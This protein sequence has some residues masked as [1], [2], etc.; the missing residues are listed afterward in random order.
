[1]PD[2]P[3]ASPAGRP[4]EVALLRRLLDGDPIAPAEASEYYLPLLLANRG[5]ARGYTQ[6][7][8]RVETAADDALLSFLERPDRFDATKLSLLRYLA[9]SARGDLKNAVQREARHA[10]R[11]VLLEVVELR[12]P[13]G[14]DAQTEL[15]LP[16][17]LSAEELLR[18]LHERVTDPLD[19]RALALIID[20][21]RETPA[22]AR[23]WGFTHLPMAE[24]RQLVKLNKDR[25]EKQVRRLGRQIRDGNA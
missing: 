8:H 23:I 18:R 10:S 17:G 16:G 19:R 5:W 25:L 4:D 24:Q 14:N 20:G 22:Y 15:E 1:M 21:V 2:P 3:T 11:R 13:G 9:M 6:D 7:E 12:P